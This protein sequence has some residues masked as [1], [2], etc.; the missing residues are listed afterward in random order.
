EFA[1]D[2]PLPATSPTVVN[3]RSG[4]AATNSVDTTAYLHR[5][6]NPAARQTMVEPDFK[7]NPLTFAGKMRMGAGRAFSL[8]GTANGRPGNDSI[9]VGKR[10]EVIPDGNSD[11]K[12]LIEAIE[13]E[14]AL[15]LMR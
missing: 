9:A 11:R 6:L 1:P 5:E 4:L 14:K 3:P 15:P 10:F 8:D 7:D 2:T 12:V 13:Y